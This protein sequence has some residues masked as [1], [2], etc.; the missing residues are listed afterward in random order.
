MVRNASLWAFFA[1][2]LALV[3][4]QPAFADYRAGRTAWDAGRHVEAVKEWRA[5]ADRSDARA[6][7]ALG[8]AFAKGV[9]VPQDFVE[10]H[11]WLN[12]AAGR[13]SAA[14]VGERDAL[15]GE[16]TAEERAEA[17]KLARAWRP[18]GRPAAAPA[19]PASAPPPASPPPRRA[20]V[21]AQRLLGALGY[22]PGAA[23]GI[24]GRRSVE[25]YRAF[26]RDSRMAA[27]D[28]LTVDGIVAVCYTFTALTTKKERRQWV[29]PELAL[30]VY[31]MKRDRCAFNMA[32]R[33]SP[34]PHPADGRGLVLSGKGG[35]V[36]DAEAL[37]YE[38]GRPHP[39]RI[40]AL[41]IERV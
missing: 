1:T 28:I 18:G 11:K 33:E 15:A 37:P 39:C 16:M 21:E 12:L 27:S 29:E 32:L 30:P 7:L 14:A 6:M 17:R 23:D 3:S 34:A 4:A 38:R 22:R 40:V 41:P 9:G 19:A 13:G 10:A 2:V 8:R 25:A 31:Q 5:A 36:R 35:G 26:L 24:W 20:L